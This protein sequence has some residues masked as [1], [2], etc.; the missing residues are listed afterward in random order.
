MRGALALS[1]LSS[2][3]SASVPAHVACGRHQRSPACGVPMAARVCTVE[4]TVTPVDSALV[5]DYTALHPKDLPRVS[6]RVAA[7]WWAGKECDCVP[8]AF[9]EL[10]RFGFAVLDSPEAMFRSAPSSPS[11]S[12]SSLPSFNPGWFSTMPPAEDT[13]TL[14]YRDWLPAHTHP[15]F[16]EHLHR[17]LLAHGAPTVR[18]DAPTVRSDAP[19]VRSD[20]PTVNP[21]GVFPGETYLGVASIG[22]P[23]RR[24]IPGTQANL[25]FPHQDE[26]KL[27]CLQ[28]EFALSGDPGD[29]LE[30]VRSVP[31]EVRAALAAAFPPPGG[32][33]VMTSG[34]APGGPM[35]TSG[36][37]T[38]GGPTTTRGD[39]PGGGRA[40][41]SGDAPGGRMATSGPAASGR[42]PGG[43]TAVV[44]RQVNFWLPEPAGGDK[45]LVLLSLE[46]AAALAEGGPGMITRCQLPRGPGSREPS[47]L[48]GGAS[49]V[50]LAAHRNVHLTDRGLARIADGMPEH[51]F[52]V[53]KPVIFV[54]SWSQLAPPA[55]PPTEDGGLASA[56]ADVSKGVF[57]CGAVLEGVGHGS[58]EMRTAVFSRL[59]RPADPQP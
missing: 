24:G 38:P 56:R 46:A 47:D 52:L 18:S 20:A 31:G 10:A 54:S 15:A 27:S 28:A 4:V 58:T 22:G 39:A 30:G 36:N 40:T 16:A 3:P 49:G 45:C 34:D 8:S 53:N 48:P 32:G 1:P 29:P 37:N 42:A 55:G 11:S 59:D 26:C 33:R 5:G 19:T 25:T 2:K 57:H 44:C 13:T 23:R 41:T 43:P 50:H 17:I 21:G 6:A 14:H 51:I 9:A 12:P 7:N 35:P